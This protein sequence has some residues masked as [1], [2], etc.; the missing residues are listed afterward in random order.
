VVGQYYYCFIVLGVLVLIGCFYGIWRYRRRKNRMKM[1][2]DVFRFHF[3]GKQDDADDNDD[4]KYGYGY[5]HR[6]GSGVNYTDEIGLHWTDIYS[7]QE[8]D[9]A[10]STGRNPNGSRSYG[11][12]ANYIKGGNKA[13]NKAGSKMALNIDVASKFN[14]YRPRHQVR[15]IGRDGVG[16]DD[17]DG[18][19]DTL[20]DLYGGGDLDMEE[21]SAP[22]GSKSGRT[23]VYDNP[24]LHL[25][26][27]F[28]MTGG[29][30]N[31]NHRANAS[32]N[33]D[34]EIGVDSL[35]VSWHENGHHA[36][37]SGSGS[38]LISPGS[39]RRAKSPA[40]GQGNVS[41]RSHLA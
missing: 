15:R 22:I 8:D 41:S 19:G 38:G 16:E 31:K 23:F 7:G 17:G 11:G 39:A 12:S 1:R 20:A 10:V 24:G 27:R 40:G 3:E 5:G 14:S 29:V 30:A 37:G 4:D 36:S 2:D 32:A 6:S 35:G 33:F 13:G 28:R 18:G 25:M 9:I 21:V 26:A 34:S